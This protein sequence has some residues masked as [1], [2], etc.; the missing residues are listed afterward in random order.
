MMTKKKSKHA[1]KIIKLVIIAIF[2]LIPIFMYFLV[3]NHGL[4]SNSQD[5]GAFGSFVGGIYAPIVAII[6]VYVLIKTLYS[7]DSHNKSSQRHQ[8]KER[9]LENVRWLTD[10]LNGMLNKKYPLS[11]PKVFYGNLRQ[12]LIKKL[13]NDYNPDGAII[14]NKAIELMKENEEI[15]QDECIIFDDLFYRVTHNE[16]IDD[17][18]LSCMILIAKLS[19]E[20]RF[21]LMQYAKAH[22]HRAAKDLKFW[23]SF[24][25]IPLSLSSL[26]KS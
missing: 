17:G 4:S 25:N 12:M 20:E 5:W 3:F 16:D 22:E 11:Q 14:K 8:E 9:H 19:P 1:F 7:M 6:S 24:D 13:E 21:W 10:L 23:R 26:V 2:S 15:F 18:A